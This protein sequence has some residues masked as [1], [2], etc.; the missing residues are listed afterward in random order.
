MSHP[1]LDD[2]IKKVLNEDEGL[3]DAFSI[4][5]ELRS[6]KSRQITLTDQFHN[7]ISRLLTTLGEAI[8]GLEIQDEQVPE[9]DVAVSENG[10]TVEY[11]GDTITLRPDF[12]TKRWLVD[13]PKFQRQFDDL[14]LSS[15][16]TSVAQKIVKYFKVRYKVDLENINR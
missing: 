4:L 14:P 12:G 10:L 9:L 5:G 15:D 1:S 3:A 16:V 6:L 8:R 13:N 11:V 7:I 2:T